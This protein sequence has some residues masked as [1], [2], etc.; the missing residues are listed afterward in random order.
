MASLPRENDMRLKECKTETGFRDI[1][2]LIECVE[3][4]PG[5]PFYFEWH[6]TDYA[7][8]GMAGWAFCDFSLWAPK[9][10]EASW[11][12]V[13]PGFSSLSEALDYPLLD[14]KSVRERFDELIFYEE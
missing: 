6:D 10:C 7:C 2:E 3:P 4:A 12:P 8:D 14:G 13:T 5:M 9:G 11:Q 1:D